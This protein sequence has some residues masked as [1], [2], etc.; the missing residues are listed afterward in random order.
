MSAGEH[1]PGPWTSGKPFTENVGG[2]RMVGIPISGS[3]RAI[4]RVWMGSERHLSNFAE[5]DAEALANARLIDAAPAMADE[6]EN[7]ALAA[8]ALAGRL[9][10]PTPVQM[11]AKMARKALALA[12]RSA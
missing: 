5:P 8:E 6:L 4:A 9:Q 1:T 10:N 2:T 3:G 7:I 12:G 11:L